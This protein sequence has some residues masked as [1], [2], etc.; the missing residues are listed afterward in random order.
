M[1]DKITNALKPWAIK[2]ATYAKQMRDIRLLG[3]NLFVAIALLVTWNSVGVIQANYELQQDLSRL[4]QENEIRALE[5][6]TLRLRNE[7]YQTDQYLELAARK[8][9]SK[10]AAGETLVL[11]PDEVALRYSH[12]PLPNPEASLATSTKPKYQQNFEAW[13]EF[14]FRR[15]AE[16]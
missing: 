9:F 7:Y 11:V 5:N 16:I 15:N 14:F 13:M 8:Q 1:Q 2:A 12:E 10:A 3:L 4:Q 6:E